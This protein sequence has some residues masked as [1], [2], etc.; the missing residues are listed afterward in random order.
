[1]TPTTL[2]LELAALAQKMLE[3]GAQLEYHAGFDAD[4]AFR[5]RELA[6][7]AY[8]VQHWADELWDKTQSR[9]VAE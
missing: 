1:M 7:S 9:E 8:V 5:G 4:A 3:L 2:S 6:K